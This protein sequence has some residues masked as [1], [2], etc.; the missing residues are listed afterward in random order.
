MADQRCQVIFSDFGTAKKIYRYISV[1]CIFLGFTELM[2][3][4]VSEMLLLHFLA[5]FAQISYISVKIVSSF[6]RLAVESV[7]F[8]FKKAEIGTLTEK[9]VFSEPIAVGMVPQLISW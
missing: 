3:G 9:S 5:D 4:G 6:S 7:L 1:R 8:G 2:S